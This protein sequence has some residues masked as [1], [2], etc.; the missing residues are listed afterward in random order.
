[1]LSEVP[2][3][4]LGLPAIQ[5]PDLS[6]SLH[7]DTT[8]RG[9]NSPHSPHPGIRPQAPASV[10]PALENCH[11]CLSSI[12][13]WNWKI[14]PRRKP[15]TTAEMASGACLF[16]GISLPSP[17]HSGCPPRPATGC[18]LYKTQLLRSFRRRVRVTQT[19]Q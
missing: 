6:E 4:A 9:C 15:E 18:F 10:L 8:G 3:S 11:F 7:A 2:S 14:P 5:P 17:A 1:M 13:R 16:S 19:N 12:L